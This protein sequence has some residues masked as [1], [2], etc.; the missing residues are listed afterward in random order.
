MAEVC[1]VLVA[2]RTEVGKELVVQHG[3]GSQISQL[4][5]IVRTSQSQTYHQ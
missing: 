5:E 2:A 4:G 1:T 3:P